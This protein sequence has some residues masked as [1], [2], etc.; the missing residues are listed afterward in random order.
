MNS[1]HRPT[2]KELATDEKLGCKLRT[3]AVS[4]HSD[5]FYSEILEPTNQMEQNIMET[6][7]YIAKAKML[8]AV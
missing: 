8:D 4:L 1:D 5:C 3:R 6:E 7:L 2:G